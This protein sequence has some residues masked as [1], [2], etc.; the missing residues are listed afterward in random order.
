MDKDEEAQPPKIPKV[1][2]ILKSHSWRVGSG[3]AG[4]LKQHTD[5]LLRYDFELQEQGHGVTP[6][7]V[8]RKAC[9]ISCDFKDKSQNAQRCVARQWLAIQDLCFQ[10]G[11][12]NESQRYL[13]ETKEEALDWIKNITWV[14]ASQPNRHPKFIMN[15]DQTPVFLLTI[16]RRLSRKW[17]HL[18]CPIWNLRMTLKEPHLL[19]P[20]VR[21]V[22]SWSP[23]SYSRGSQKGEL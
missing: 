3:R 4:L 5:I 7:M 8:M 6:E 20:S 18:L 19:Q 17:E 12:T 1:C 9:I 2:T 21:M 10:M 16:P 13:A 23:W 14:K 11:T 22:H 15:M